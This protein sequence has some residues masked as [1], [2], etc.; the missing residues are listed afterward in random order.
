MGSGQWAAGILSTHLCV[1]GDDCHLS[2][3]FGALWKR[4]EELEFIPR[5][6]MHEF[7][8][9]EKEMIRQCAAEAVSSGAVLGIDGSDCSE[10]CLDLIETIAIT[11]DEEMPTRTY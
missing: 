3:D 10:D 11:A 1:N 6:E 9:D 7:E 5:I 8:L 2:Q 4:G